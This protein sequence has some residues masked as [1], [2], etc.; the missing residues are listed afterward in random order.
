[1]TFGPVRSDRPI[2]SLLSL[3]E[4]R[5][6]E[7][8]LYR[9][10][11][12]A[13]FC[14]CRGFSYSPEETVHGLGLR[15][16]WQRFG[17]CSASGHLVGCRNFD[18]RC[19]ACVCYLNIDAFEE[20]PQAHATTVSSILLLPKGLDGSRGVGNVVHPRLQQVDPD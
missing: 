17:L 5:E 18:H 6:R 9:H 11:D 12:S 7:H 14:L 3:L 2:H 4:Q 19:Y 20:L 8:Q 1:M 13:T 15:R 10:R 16:K